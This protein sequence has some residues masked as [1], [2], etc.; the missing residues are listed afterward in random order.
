MYPALAYKP[1]AQLRPT[2]IDENYFDRLAAFGF[3]CLLAAVPG[4]L[5]MA[6]GALHHDNGEAY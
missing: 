4:K 5:T 1:I 2:Q 6:W 3:A